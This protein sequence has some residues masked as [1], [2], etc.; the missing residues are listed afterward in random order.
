MKSFL[1]GRCQTVVCEGR[2]SQ[3]S[4]VTST[5]NSF[6]PLLFL[7][8]LNDLPDR[9]HSEV[10]LFADDA[11]LYGVIVNDIDCDQL[12]EELITMATSKANEI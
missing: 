3:A 4:P 12:Q 11:S 1:T 10:K 8:Y 7:T 5:G 9:L 2:S 6:G